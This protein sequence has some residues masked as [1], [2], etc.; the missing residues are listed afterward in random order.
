[1]N[2]SLKNRE[3]LRWIIPAALVFIVALWGLRNW[4]Q[5][6]RGSTAAAPQTQ[7]VYQL[8]LVPTFTPT[9]QMGEAAISSQEEITASN[10][11]VEAPALV[12]QIA[13]ETPVPSPSATPIPAERLDEAAHLHRYGYY[14]EEQRLLLDLIDDANITLADR[15]EA[16]YRLVR[17]Y[18]A[19]DNYTS[20]LAAVEQFKAEAVELPADDRRRINATFLEAEA[21]AALRRFDPAIAAYTAFVAE[22]PELTETIYELMAQVYRDA[23][24]PGGAAAAYRR[25]AD[26]TPNNSAL[27]RLLEAQ[28]SMLETAGRWL[29]AGAVYDEILSFA[30]VPNYRM[31]IGQRA[32]V[33]YAQGGDEATAIQRWQAV[34]S[35]QP[36]HRNAH[37]SLAA[38]V[39]RNAPVDLYLRGSINMIAGSYLPAI[40]AFDNFIQANPDDLR[41]GN[42]L[43]SIGQAYL[44]LGNFAQAQS[45]LDRVLVEFPACACF[46]QAWLDQGRLAILSGD[47]TG[48]RRVYRTFAREYPNDPLAAE[49]LWRSALSAISADNQIEAAVDFFALADAFPASTRARDALYVLGI[50]SIT[51]RLYPQALI[52]FTRLQT[53]YPNDRWQAATYWRGRA[54]HAL[55]QREEARAQWQS[56]VERDPQSYFGVL[57][58]LALLGADQPGRNIFN[59][60]DQLPNPASTLAGDDGSQAFAEQWLSG[61]IN[62]PADQLALLPAAVRADVDL[63]A[64]EL[65]LRLDRRG[66]ALVHLRRLADRYSDNSQITYALA[67]HFEE[68]GAYGLSITAA[69]RFLNLSQTP[70]V[71]NAPIFIQRLVYPIR[72]QEIAEREARAHDIDPLLFYSLLRQESLFEE[73]ARS[74]AAAQGLA[75][76]I[77]STGAEI[78][79]R[80]NYPNY[81]N[82]LI[83][84]PHIN[85]R[86]GAFYLDWVRDYVNGSLAAAL[87]GYNA[88]PGNARTWQ[89]LANGD[90]TL[91]VELMTYSEPR[92][93][94]QM[95]LSH[96]YH[97]NRLYG[98]D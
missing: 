72:F 2:I 48:G 7:N 70:L 24:N 22:H 31:T 91:F 88:G 87:A 63:Q 54:H 11:R 50:G 41:V 18:L 62:V 78:A 8:P 98:E 20:A 10:S 30:V 59:G 67:L 97:Y 81:S 61:R 5:G 75:Q 68:L 73:G 96:Y 71:E 29:E 32:G 6:R 66:E 39:E 34:I 27:A 64:G 65:L 16:R 77:P 33:A 69:S 26:A 14:T 55:N 51:N 53:D 25:A 28:A 3:L 92:L 58:G 80:L 13:T 90:E 94:I 56:L 36:I 35:E 46:G 60:V 52:S 95:I 43:H 86:F 17:S 82:A 4:D 19:E 21:L 12:A 40:A 74:H 38:L 57:A 76:I 44:E 23:G 37:P 85:L 79:G 49:A 9:P 1:M 45:F 47:A 89:G 84:R 93:Y 42:A 15:L 83:Y